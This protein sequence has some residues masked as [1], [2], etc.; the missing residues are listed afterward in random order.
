MSLPIL[1]TRTHAARDLARLQGDPQTAARGQRHPVGE[2]GPDGAEAIEL[3][4]DLAGVTAELRELLLELVDL[5]DHVD[6]DHHVVV[7]EVEDRARV[8]EEDVGIE[9]EILLHGGPSG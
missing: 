4:R 7:G 3:A 6:R 8:V 9:N 5:L 1:V 2:V